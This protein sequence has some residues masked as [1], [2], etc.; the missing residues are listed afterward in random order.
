[1]G[2]AWC[3]LQVMTVVVLEVAH[4]LLLLLVLELD[5]VLR[6]VQDAKIRSEI[7]SCTCA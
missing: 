7:M 2:L 4:N 6:L 5:Q 1:M 3:I